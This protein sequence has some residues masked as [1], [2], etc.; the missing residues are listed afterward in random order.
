[1]SFRTRIYETK[2][3]GNGKRIV[4]SGTL[5][6][7]FVYGILKF[8]IKAIYFCC[9]GWLFWIIKMLYIIIKNRKN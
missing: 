1:M 3:M 4:T 6:D 5:S 2:K 9:I 8:V 7:W